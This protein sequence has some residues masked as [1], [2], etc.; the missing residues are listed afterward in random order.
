M[1]YVCPKDVGEASRL[2]KKAGSKAHIL[3]G[4]TDLLVKL[5][6]GFVE[7]KLVVD[8]K[9][10]K[11]LRDITKT[12]SGF[13]IGAAVTCAE[14]AEDKA[15]VKAWPGI[16]EGAELI[17]S[18]QIQGRA[19]MAGNLCNGSPAADSVPAL[20]AAGA[21]VEIAGGARPRKVKVANIVTAPGKTCLKAGEF[22]TAFH[23]PKRLKGESDAYLRFIPRTEMDIAVV[24]AAVNLSLDSK[25][26]IKQARLALGAV[27]PTVI[28]MSA[29]I[30]IGTQASSAILEQ[31]SAIASKA[32]TPIDDKR[33]SRE[34]RIQVSG[35]L[36]KRA[37]K[38]A[39]NRAK[40]QLK[41]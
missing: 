25:G 12:A 11:T 5:R 36:A 30:L 32:A 38:I 31:L 21:M 16:V 6:T 27:G 40:S 26:I 41:G 8:I 19:T 22:I 2:L 39:Y 7:P 29:K 28:D 15:L 1:E 4:G 37:A 24:G 10:L 34:F 3:N 33:G 18:T 9:N 23:L 20:I 13:R 14:M 17:G 35:V